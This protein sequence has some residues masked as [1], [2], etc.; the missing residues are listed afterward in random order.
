MTTGHRK[1]RVL[2]PLTLAGADETKLPVVV[3]QAQAL[4]AKVSVL[5][6]LDGAAPGDGMAASVEEVAARAFLDE[7]VT[8]LRTDGVCAQSEV[9]HGAVAPTILRVAHEQ[10]ASLIIV[11][12]TGRRG[13]TRH[14]VDSHAS[15]IA[16]DAPCPVLVVKRVG[17]TEPA[18][19][20][21]RAA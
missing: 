7:V 13:W 3:Q 4:R 21:R 2:V 16:R 18:R 6:V 17:R 10:G 11:G 14:L 19:D 20:Q 15:A 12:A 1:K 9:R 5:H 8:L